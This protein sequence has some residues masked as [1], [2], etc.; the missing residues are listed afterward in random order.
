MVAAT[1]D[2]D[3]KPQVGPSPYRN[4]GIAHWFRDWSTYRDGP[5]SRGKNTAPVYDPAPGIRQRYDNEWGATVR[6]VN[7]VANVGHD[8]SFVN[9][10]IPGALTFTVKD[11]NT[12]M[13]EFD[14]ENFFPL[15]G[16][17]SGFGNEWW[18]ADGANSHNY[19]FT[20]EMEFDFQV[21]TGMVFEFR[22]DDDVWVFIDKQLVLDLGGIH[23]KL[24]GSFNVTD[25]IGVDAVGSMKKLRV[26]Y[27]ERHSSGSNLKITTNIVAPPGAIDISTKDNL[28]G[29]GIVQ[30][31]IS[32][33][34]DE[35]VTLYSVVY[36]DNGIVLKPGDYDCDH[37]TWTITGPDG[38]STTKRACSIELA[39]SIAG[40]V[41]IKVVYDN[42]KD[43]ALTGGANMNVNALPPSSVR[44]QLENA[45]RTG[46][47]DVYFKP[48]DT[49]L[50]VYAVLYD[51][52][53]NY[54]GAIADAK[55]RN[56]NNWYSE[57]A[58]EW[59]SVETDVATV[60]PRSGGSVTVKKEERGAGTESKLIVSYTVCGGTLTAC[61][62]L[63]D[64][65]GVGSKSVGA[66]TV[67]PPFVPGVDHALK[68]FNNNSDVRDFYQNVLSNSGGGEKGILIGVD[69]PKRLDPSTPGAPDVGGQ[70][71]YGKVI[72][73]DAVGNVVKTAALYRAKN[74]AS[75]GYVWDGRNQKN[76]FVGP[77]TYLVRVSGRD[78]DKKPF[79]VQKRVGVTTTKK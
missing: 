41:T 17:V 29:S 15:D 50:K 46:S 72:I 2:A 32:K 75:Y 24:N 21:K 76:R 79:F 59:V 71:Q 14:N 74:A 57:G 39:D 9:K 25:K 31:A 7:E 38:K 28:G 65:V 67:G 42:K 60:N 77:G 73:Y 23:E 12:G 16:N 45:A 30:G 70:T 49:E 44:I 62:T 13:Y 11:R 56:G 78:A 68:P 63:R 27:A 18:S 8:T 5:Y 51:K 54:T 33:P 52:Y 20:M 19:A 43:P 34:A 48:S 47:E 4:L 36:D 53:G 1:L 69:S 61:V 6:V 3:N 55:T 37:V 26:F 58:A 22:G 35:K 10:V 40:A 66:I 64:T